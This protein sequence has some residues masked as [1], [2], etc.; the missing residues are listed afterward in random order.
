LTLSS[1][2]LEQNRE[3]LSDE[4]FVIII[5]KRD[6][7][8]DFEN[9]EKIIRGNVRKFPTF[10][11]GDIVLTADCKEYPGGFQEGDIIEAHLLII[12]EGFDLKNY[13]TIYNMIKNDCEL[14][15]SVGT[16]VKPGP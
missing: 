5:R 10:L 1:I 9:D 16:T 11:Q 13:S 12:P 14:L 3:G 4:H 15:E 6:E 7:H 8:V 2:S